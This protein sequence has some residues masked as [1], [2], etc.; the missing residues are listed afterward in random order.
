VDDDNGETI[1]SHAAADVLL[2][3]IRQ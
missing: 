2:R 1:Q 3:A